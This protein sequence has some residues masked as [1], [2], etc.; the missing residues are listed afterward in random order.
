[1]AAPPAY[2]FLENVVGF[3]ESQ[4]Y[5]MWMEVLQQRGYSVRQYVLSPSA[6]GIP[7]E[8]PRYYCMARRNCSDFLTGSSGEIA[9]SVPGGGTGRL[10][11]GEYIEQQMQRANHPG[12]EDPQPNQQ[13]LPITEDELSPFLVSPAAMSKTS[14]WC[15][16]IV[17]GTSKKTACFTKG[18]TRFIRGTGSVLL[19]P[20]GDGCAKDSSSSS[21]TALALSLQ[22]RLRTGFGGGS[23]AAPHTAQ[24]S[25]TNEVCGAA[26]D[27]GNLTGETIF[28]EVKPP[29]SSSSAAAAKRGTELPYIQDL[30]SHFGGDQAKIQEYLDARKNWQFHEDASR[31]TEST[32]AAGN[33]A[34][35]SDAEVQTQVLPFWGSNIV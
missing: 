20:N 14:S 24:T 27:G 32:P 2:I 15:F 29:P 3:E 12:C 7:N 33:P 16:D 6:L 34:A 21:D 8:R 30:E 31:T 23:L 1:M 19:V 4:A 22:Q 13:L 10:T 25:S 26:N 28:S 9:R 17:E 11:V 5:S 18:Y 35:G